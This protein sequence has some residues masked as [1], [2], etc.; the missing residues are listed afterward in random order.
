MF[1]VAVGLLFVLQLLPAALVR[2]AA[3]RTRDGRCEHF[4]GREMVVDEWGRTCA[5]ET[6]W[7]E[8]TG[9][10]RDPGAAPAPCERCL[11]QCCRE[12][13]DCVSCCVSQG[14]IFKVCLR[15]CRFSSRE[16]DGIQF[17][18]RL[19]DRHFCFR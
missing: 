11:N 9:C 10:C 4:L 1:L 5:W 18:S 19:R 14:T 3:P 8:E 7:Q 17:K 13:H 16:V 6:D 12:Y 2:P 15:N